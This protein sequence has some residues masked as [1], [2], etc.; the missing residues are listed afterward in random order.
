M[1]IALEVRKDKGSSE[2]D[3]SVILEW[4]CQNCRMW[5]IWFHSTE[6]CKTGII[7][8]KW[9]L[10]SILIPKPKC[11]FILQ[12]YF[13]CNLKLPSSEKKC[14]NTKTLE[15]KKLTFLSFCLWLRIELRCLN[16]NAECYSMSMHANLTVSSCFFWNLKLL[17]SY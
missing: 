10:R 1:P 7:N 6:L 4:Y 5:I 11:M 17:L 16:A 15:L 8:L 2:M 14:K 12:N 3:L 9:L 13:M